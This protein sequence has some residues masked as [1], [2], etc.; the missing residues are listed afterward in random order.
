VPTILDLIDYPEPFMSFGESILRPGKRFIHN[1][2]NEIDQVI[3]NS[4]LGGFQRNSAALSYW[5]NYRTDPALQY[6]LA[7]DSVSRVSEFGIRL[8]A[9]R[10]RYHQS[11]LK[12]ELLVK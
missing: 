4:Y 12:N 5:Y 7:A 9:F 10:Q 11:L 2:I 3:D 1:R 6:N 8:K